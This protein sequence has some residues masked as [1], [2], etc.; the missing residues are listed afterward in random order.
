MAS[1]INNFIFLHQELDPLED[2]LPQG[3]IERLFTVSQALL[4][5]VHTS[6]GGALQNSDDVGSSHATHTGLSM[7]NSKVA[8]RKLEDAIAEENVGFFDKEGRVGQD[9]DASNDTTNTNVNGNIDINK[10]KN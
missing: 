5:G 8:V 3:L 6:Q 7:P 10:D 9:G 4:Q 1:C 2:I